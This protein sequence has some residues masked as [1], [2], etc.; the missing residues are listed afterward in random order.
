MQVAREA[1]RIHLHHRAVSQQSTLDDIFVGERRV[2]NTAFLLR[3]LLGRALGCGSLALASGFG[4]GVAG[5]RGLRGS[6]GASG[7]RSSSEG[8][9]SEGEGW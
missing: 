3:L 4:A 5:G 6:S 2:G 8:S 1:L 9:R 7:S